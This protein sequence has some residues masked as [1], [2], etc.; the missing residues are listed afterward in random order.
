LAAQLEAAERDPGRP[1]HYSMIESAA[2]E[3]GRAL[4]RRIQ[5]HAAGKAAAEGPSEAPC[6]TCG[7]TCSAELKPREVTS[8]DGPVRLLEPRA[9]CDRCRR[10]F[11]P[12]A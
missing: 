1:L 7:A 6:P 2:H 9:F 4:S 5:T 11:F 8:I 3:A 12:S 10:S